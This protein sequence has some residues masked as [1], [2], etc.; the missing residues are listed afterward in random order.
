[1]LPANATPASETGGLQGLRE[2]RK[3]ATSKGKEQLKGGDV[4]R[5]MLSDAALEHPWTTLDALKPPSG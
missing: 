1:M 3:K 4:G 2:T 5:A